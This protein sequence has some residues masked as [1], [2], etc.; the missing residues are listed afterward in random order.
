MKRRDFLKAGA[1]I[2]A[3]SVIDPRS[4]KGE[5]LESREE[6]VVEDGPLITSSPMLQNFAPTSIGVAFCVGAL[7]N[8]FVKISESPLMTDAKTFKTGGFRMTEITDKVAQVRITGLKPSTKYYYTIGAD[9][10]YYKNGHSI[11]ITGHEEDPRVYSFT[12]AGENSKASFCVINDTHRNH[13]VFETLQKTIDGISPSC[14]I[15][16][17]DACSSS[18]TIEVQQEVF[19]QPKSA[20]KDYASEIPYLLCPGNHEQRGMANRHLERVWMFRQQEERDST[21]WDLGRNFAF[22]LGDIAMIG[23]DTAED[24]VD[25]NP[26]Y[27]GLF[28]NGPYREAQAQWLKTVLKKKEIKKAKY[29]IA[30]CHIPLF[31]S[32]PNENPGDIHP[33]DTDSR[34]RTNYASWQRTCRDLW[35]PELQKAGCKL[36]ISGHQHKYRVEHPTP[37][38]PWTQIVGGGPKLGHKAIFPTVIEG[39]I[40]SGHLKIII[41]NAENGTVL[42]EFQF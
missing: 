30:F 1:A 41:H 38:R 34:F 17:G 25:E 18:E 40:E 35:M 29:I 3:L 8:A 15:W 21:F 4:L 10:I 37:D 9:K 39:K 36:V 11:K 7:A 13:S 32:R 16:N 22:R 14:V 6:P 31:D 24:K 2:A 12:T 33:D 20:R 23:L 27:A 5:T 28:N 26:K 19:L 42:D